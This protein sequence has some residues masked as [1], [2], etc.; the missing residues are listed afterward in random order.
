MSGENHQPIVMLSL[1]LAEPL[2]VFLPVSVSLL[3]LV[4]LKGDETL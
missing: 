4:V 2:P 1:L 3:I